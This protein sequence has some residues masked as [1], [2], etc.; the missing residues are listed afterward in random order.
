MNR[1]KIIFSRSCSEPNP[2]PD[3]PNGDEGRLFEACWRLL[4]SGA[5]RC[6]PI[7]DPIV[8]F[9][10]L[11]SAYPQIAPAPEQNIKLGVEF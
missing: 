4:E 2:N 7:V 10:D 8:S 3:Y 1:P 11:L 5:L 6:E 9:D